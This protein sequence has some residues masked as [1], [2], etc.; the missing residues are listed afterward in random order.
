MDALFGRLVCCGPGGTERYV[1]ESDEDSSD[2]EFL[3]VTVEH[4]RD[5]GQGDPLPP[6]QV[7]PGSLRVI[8]SSSRPAERRRHHKSSS[9]A[10]FV[11][12][13]G[14]NRE[15]QE[16]E[17]EGSG[18]AGGSSSLSTRW[19]AFSLRDLF[20]PKQQQQQQQQ[21]ER[22]GGETKRFFPG[23]DDNKRGGKGRGR[24]KGGDDDGGARRPL[25]S[26][27]E[28]RGGCLMS[29]ERR[30]WRGPPAWCG[31]ISRRPESER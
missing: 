5:G 22:R 10:S 24:G 12:P 29:P 30:G 4:R 11:Q 27:S 14:A 16:G 13:G 20:S 31:S 6:D 9:I 7:D 28:K 26:P 23:G 19:A 25:T 17:T 8:P 15:R 21:D 3:P 1:H 2:C 18:A